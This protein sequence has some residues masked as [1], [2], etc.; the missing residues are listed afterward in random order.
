M[1]NET[2]NVTRTT[3]TNAGSYTSTAS[4]SSVS[5][6]RA[7]AGNYTLTGTTKAFT[8]NPSSTAI[9]VYYPTSATGV[10]SKTVYRN[11]CSSSSTVLSTTNTGTS[12]N[13]LASTYNG[14]YGSFGGYATTV[15]TTARATTTITGIATRTETTYYIVTTGSN[16]SSITATFNYYNGSAWT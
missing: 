8:I 1:T 2:I 16:T 6:G 7:K 15:N 12:N 9:K 4:I 14:L 5:G 13:V 11:K 3:G 10:G